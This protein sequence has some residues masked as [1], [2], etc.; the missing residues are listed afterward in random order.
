MRVGRVALAYTPRRLGDLEDLRVRV[1][2][3]AVTVGPRTL[4]AFQ[5][6]RRS[7]RRAAHSLSDGRDDV[8]ATTHN[9]QKDQN[10]VPSTPPHRRHKPQDEPSKAPS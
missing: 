3:T 7:K 9:Y 4:Q 1:R 10:T 8:H 5:E 2:V 6:G